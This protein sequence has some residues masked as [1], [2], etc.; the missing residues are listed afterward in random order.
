MAQAQSGQQKR[1]ESSTE[2]GLSIVSLA[3][4]VW[5]FPLVGRTRMLTEAWSARGQHN[6]FVQVP[7]LRNALERV[8]QF[9]RPR[10]TQPIVRPWPGP[11]A[12]TW[13]RLDPTA[14][15]DTIRRR[16]RQ[17]RRQLDPLI[18][19]D[20]ATALVV[21]PV[22]TP[23]LAELPF[24]RVVYDC[25]DALDVH[26]PRPELKS[27]YVAWEDALIAR[28]DAIVTTADNLT[29]E[30]RAKRSDVPVRVIR[31]G[32]DV[33]RFQQIAANVARPSD[34]PA[35]KRPIVGFVGAL[36]RWIDW[37]LIADVVKQLPEFDF[38]FVGPDDGNPAMDG[39]A[40][41]ANTSFLGGRPYDD[42]PAY[43]NA[44]DVCW[45][46]FTQDHISRAANPVKIY[47]YLA[48][49]KPTVS[50]P[51]ADVALFENCVAVADSADAV[52][53]LLRDALRE[54]SQERRQDRLAFARR[55]T[56]Q[57]RAEEYASF[58]RQLS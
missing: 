11:R 43:M 24:H 10:E 31:N 40:A 34:L 45:V 23:W 18:D 51:V 38:V 49:G 7:S 5:N 9:A 6:V 29:D 55:N 44:F 35:G 50:T 42:V 2:T 19:W 39:V 32:V 36:Y 54:D 25:I 17:L 46:P 13:S 33:E 15:D 41:I 20:Q 4:V 47:E 57:A 27:L 58:L 56:W 26:V 28:C 48:L 37:A 21:S 53:M 1:G 52:A 16:A 8:T 3:A 30:I 12:R 22:W 14:L